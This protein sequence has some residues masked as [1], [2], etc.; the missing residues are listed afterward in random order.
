MYFF[1]F[2]LKYCIVYCRLFIFVVIMIYFGVNLEKLNILEEVLYIVI[3]YII[4]YVIIEVI[5]EC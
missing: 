2:K 3:V 1:F 5:F 4:I